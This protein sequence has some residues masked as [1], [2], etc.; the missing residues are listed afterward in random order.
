MVDPMTLLFGLLREEE[1]N[2]MEEWT[3]E[4]RMR[5]LLTYLSAQKGYVNIPVVNGLFPPEA[6]VV[7]TAEEALWTGWVIYPISTDT[8]MIKQIKI[9]PDGIRALAKHLQASKELPS[10]EENSQQ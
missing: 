10:A 8:T 5:E 3:Y 7:E 1:V 4:R 6:K 2:K 9:T